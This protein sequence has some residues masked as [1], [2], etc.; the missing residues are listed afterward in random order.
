MTL[1]SKNLTIS[2]SDDM[3]QRMRV[4][5]AMRRTSVNDM[6]RQYFQQEI[7]LEA[8]DSRASEWDAFFAKID[9]AATETQRA[10]KGGL[11]S[12]D[13]LYDEALRDRSLLR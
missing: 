8:S 10:A 6:V 9:A 3:I 12:R 2:L 4:I 5:A 11:P 13:E 7:D 1:A